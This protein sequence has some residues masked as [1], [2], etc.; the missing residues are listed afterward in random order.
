MKFADFC[1]SDKRIVQWLVNLNIE[2]SYDISE[3]LYGNED[4]I[5]VKVVHFLKIIYNNGEAYE[6]WSGWSK[7]L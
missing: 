1:F 4:D 5:S 7:K 6:S 2:I 3:K